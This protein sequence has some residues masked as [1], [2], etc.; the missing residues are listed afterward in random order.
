VKRASGDRISGVPQA[1]QKRASS[2]LGRAQRGHVLMPRAK[3][4]SS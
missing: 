2:G 4:G 1:E 3:D